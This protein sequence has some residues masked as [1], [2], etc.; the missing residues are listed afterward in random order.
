MDLQAAFRARLLGNPTI[1]NLTGGRI[2]W[3]DRPSSTG[4][5]AIVLTKVSP[6]RAWTHEG[7]DPMVNPRVQVDIYGA[8]FASVGPIAAAVQAE[9]ER[10]DRATVGGWKFVPPALLENDV[11]PGPEDL[12]GGGKAYRVMH[13]YSFWAQPA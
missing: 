6:G 9:M 13:D 7:A 3:G 11:W 2:S 1:A 10:E 12:I 5:P 4:L 8:T